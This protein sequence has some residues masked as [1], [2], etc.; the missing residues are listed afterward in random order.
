M[1]CFDI[2]RR[3]QVMVKVTIHTRQRAWKKTQKLLESLTAEDL[4]QAAKEERKYYKINNP[5]VLELLKLL[6]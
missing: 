1:V 5:A 2:I 4:R 6:G 3:E